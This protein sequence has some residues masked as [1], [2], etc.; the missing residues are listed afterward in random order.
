[1]TFGITSGQIAQLNGIA[2]SALRK[3]IL[4]AIGQLDPGMDQAHRAIVENGDSFRAAISDA[5]TPVIADVLKRFLL[6]PDYSDEEIE[7]R[8]E[9]LSGYQ[10]KSVVLQIG[11][12]QQLFPEIGNANLDLLERVK[13]GQ[14]EIPAGAEGWFAIPHW[15]KIGKT[16][17]ASVDRVFFTLMYV[18]GRFHNH[19][20]GKLGSRRLRETGKKVCGMEAL[21]RSQ[22]SDILLV[23]AQFGLRHRGR[24]VR[25]A[26][27]VLGG[28]EFGL[29]AYEVGIML[30]S[31]L[32]RLKHLDDLWV[33]CPGDEY[34]PDG[35][36]D[37]APYFGTDGVTLEFDQCHASFTSGYGSASG[38]L[39]Q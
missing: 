28:N 4:A 16:Y 3:A 7:S 21:R 26:R 36:F 24:S 17:R 39:P 11:K 2:E 30:L 10:P 20:E 23:P 29:G 8:Q 12:L 37:C 1:M 15:S 31:H 25:R 18:H 27:A 19:L 34:A 32:E 9:Y 38:F 22:N 33:D 6:P 5:V 13:N 14:A 35:D